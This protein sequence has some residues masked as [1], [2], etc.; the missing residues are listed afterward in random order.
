MQIGQDYNLLLTFSAQH[1]CPSDLL[2]HCLSASRL[3]LGCRSVLMHHGRCVFWS[4]CVLCYERAGMHAAQV[5]IELIAQQTFSQRAHSWG[6]TI[7]CRC[8]TGSCCMLHYIN[9]RYVRVVLQY[10]L[11][12]HHFPAGG[13]M[14]VNA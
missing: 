3:C 2:F 13:L 9:T 4:A 5:W 6:S 14:H 1:S 7:K 12:Q 8:H 11:F 10:L